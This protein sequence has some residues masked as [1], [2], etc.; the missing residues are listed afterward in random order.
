MSK[1]PIFIYGPKKSTLL[2]MQLKMVG[3]MLKAQTQ[4]QNLKESIEK[5]L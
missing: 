4:I 3:L 2:T 5:I 1:I